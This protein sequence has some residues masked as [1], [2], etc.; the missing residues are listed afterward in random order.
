MTTRSAFNCCFSPST[1]SPLT[2]VTRSTVRSVPAGG[3]FQHFRRGVECMHLL[4]KTGQDGQNRPS[5]GPISMACCQLGWRIWRSFQPACRRGKS[6]RPFLMVLEIIGMTGK[7]PDS[8]APAD[9]GYRLI[10]PVVK[11]ESPGDPPVRTA[12]K[13]DCPRRLRRP[14]GGDKDTVASRCAS[15]SPTALMTFR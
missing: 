7:T 15:T 2:R 1:V 10:L 3:F 9:G 5:P 11:P 13:E 12:S 6:Q 4:K 14:V 8:A